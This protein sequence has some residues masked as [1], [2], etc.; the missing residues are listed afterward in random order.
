MMREA[1]GGIL[2]DIIGEDL[3]MMGIFIGVTLVIG[4]ALKKIINQSSAKFIQK[5]K[6]SKLIH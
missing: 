3:L 2:W 1:A 6:E 4:L 5:A